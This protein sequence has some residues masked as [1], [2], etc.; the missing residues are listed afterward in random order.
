MRI[1]NIFIFCFLLVSN[2]SRA[3]LFPADSALLNYRIIGF[4]FP[5]EPKADNYKIELC[6]GDYTGN[7]FDKHITITLKG[8]TNRIIGKVPAFGQVYSWR[9]TALQGS[10]IVAPGKVHHFSTGT[11]PFIDTPAYRMTIKHKAEK[12]KDG[13]FFADATRALYDM[14]GE[15]VWFLPHIDGVK[16][17]SAA[18]RDLK[19]SGYGTITL[20]IEA[21]V[22]EI[23]YNGKI[24][25][26]GPDGRKVRTDTLQGYHHEITRLA[27]GHYMTL[28]FDPVPKR[29]APINRDSIMQLRKADTGKVKNRR[30]MLRKPRFGK[31][32]EYD[33]AGSLVWS[34][35]A[36]KY[37]ENIDLSAYP[38]MAQ[39]DVHENSFYFDEA[40][41]VIYLS[42]RNI[43]QVLKISYPSGKVVKA[44]GSINAAT[45]D[46]VNNLFCGQHAIRWSEH[47]YLYLFDNGCSSTEAPK[48]IRLK[49]PASDEEKLTETWEFSCPVE[50][51]KLNASRQNQ[52]AT[53]GGNAIELP[54]QSMLIS[55]CN[56]YSNI[57]IVTMAKKIIW[58]AAIEKMNPA[59]HMWQAVPLYRASLIT[60]PEK[61]NELIWKSVER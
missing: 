16:S 14:A 36:G 48:V 46:T 34:W 30:I 39:N 47:D 58:E 9:V 1:T 13:Y 53:S 5:T 41:H 17:D 19:L 3:Q 49:E 45:G 28:G 51:I 57:Y 27:N 40:H 24:L 22:F 44:Y 18:V 50:P 31:L 52:P 11:G 55:T 26:K 15:P 23:D 6:K 29:P 8:K 54:D 20:L 61:L 2:H 56:P 43:S 42:F 59:T 4:T 10:K 32:M 7:D 35:D 38:E 21:D 37:F 33:A 12:Y 25:W 60:D